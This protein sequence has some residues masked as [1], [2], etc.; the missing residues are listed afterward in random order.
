MHSKYQ[1]TQTCT[2]Y[3][4]KNVNKRKYWL[5]HLAFQLVSSIQQAF[6]LHSEVTIS[7]LICI[8]MMFIF[9]DRLI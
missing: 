8:S 1:Q 7:F 3:D 6:V 4:I 9:S 5:N 2:S